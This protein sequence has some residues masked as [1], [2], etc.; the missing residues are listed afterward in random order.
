MPELVKGQSS[1]DCVAYA[2]RQFESDSRQPLRVDCASFCL[3][4][5]FLSFCLF[6]LSCYYSILFKMNFHNPLF[7]VDM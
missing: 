7:H 1:S 6:Y 2:Q 5:V 4:F 3:L